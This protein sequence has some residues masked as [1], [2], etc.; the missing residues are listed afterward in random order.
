MLE[1]PECQL[2]LCLDSDPAALCRYSD[3]TFTLTQDNGANASFA[4]FGTG[5]QIYG[6]KRS[7][8]GLYQVTIDSV[9]YPSVTGAAPV[10]PLFQTSLFSTIALHPGYHTVTITNLQALFLDVDFV[11]FYL[12]E[13]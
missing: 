2:R 10:T 11:C 6:A 8:H 1:T 5:V 13:A 9:V 12:S 3:G 7:N 4:F